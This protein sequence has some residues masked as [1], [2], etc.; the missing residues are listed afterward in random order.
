LVRRRVIGSV[1][2]TWLPLL[3]LSALEGKAWAGNAAVPFL[4]DM[5][6]HS[7]FLVALPLNVVFSCATFSMLWT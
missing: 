6:A 4:Q 1:I 3:V 2:I 5:E 7:R